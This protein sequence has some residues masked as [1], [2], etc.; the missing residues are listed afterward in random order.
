[1]VKAAAGEFLVVS[2]PFFSHFRWL[3][4]VI[5]KLKSEMKLRGNRWPASQLDRGAISPNFVVLKS[6]QIL[7]SLTLENHNLQRA[8]LLVKTETLELDDTSPTNPSLAPQNCFKTA[9]EAARHN[10]NT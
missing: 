4:R 1:M 7:K 10:L 5:R 3:R 8:Q 6:L 9:S 2:H